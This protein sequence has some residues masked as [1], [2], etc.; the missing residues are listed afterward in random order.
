MDDGTERPGLFAKGGVGR[1]LLVLTL[2]TMVSFVCACGLLI[3]IAK[4]GSAG[5]RASRAD[6]FGSGW[7]EGKKFADGRTITECVSEVQ[8]RGASECS[9]LVPLCDMGISAFTGSCI[10]AAADDGYCGTVPDTSELDAS[11]QWKG[12]ACATVGGRWCDALMGDVQSACDSRKQHA[13][14]DAT[15][16]DPEE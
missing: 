5:F 16:D 11:I 13:R 4:L 9:N 7:Q 2:G 1:F 14:D 15:A 6:Q 12:T 3:G 10:F 8:R